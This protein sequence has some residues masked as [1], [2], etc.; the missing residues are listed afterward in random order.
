MTTT[1]MI[2]RHGNTFA[3]GQTVTRV[4]RRTDLPLVESGQ[5][6]ARA[7]GAW[8]RQEG[9]EPDVIFTSTLQRTIRMAELVSEVLE[10]N[11]PSRALPFLD[12]I[13][14]GEDENRPETEVV[15]RLGEAVLKRWDHE[16]TPPPGWDVDPEAI[17]S[18]WRAF[19][20]GVALEYSGRTVLAVTSNGIARFAPCLCAPSQVEA[21]ASP[22]KLAT[23]ALAVM[24]HEPGSIYWELAEWNLRP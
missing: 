22:L 10:R 8:L 11:I 9:L 23:G 2:L 15:A 4:G 21:L 17:R 14:Y 24:R 18:A 1:L 6:Q 16:A 3:P 19:A 12:E 13:D 7:A 5:A 20:A